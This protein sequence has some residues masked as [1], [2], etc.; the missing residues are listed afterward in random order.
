M[1]IPE[2]R[3]FVRVFAVT[4]SI[5]SLASDSLAAQ[6]LL[7]DCPWAGPAPVGIGIERLRCI[8]GECEINIRAG[9]GELGHRFSTEPRIDRLRA[10]SPG[11]LREGDII[12]SVDGWPIT[13]RAG[14]RRLARLTAESYVTLGLR[15][16]GRYLE[17]RLK[18]RSGCP[19]SGLA[20]RRTSAVD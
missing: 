11:A 13:T 1:K 20:V 3:R 18:A 4:V 17:V 12:A 16:E 8:G 7:A 10:E 2:L 6:E 14:G 5:A 9:D 19:I 15:R